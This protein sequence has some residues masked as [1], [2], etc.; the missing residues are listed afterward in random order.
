[1]G[2]VRLRFGAFVFYAD[3][4]TDSDDGTMA[5]Y[6]GS[7]RRPGCVLFMIY[8]NDSTAILQSL[9]YDL[10][11]ASNQPMPKNHG[12]RAML[13]AGLGFIRDQFPH[14]SRVSL[15]D[16]MT[17]QCEGKNVPT[18]NMSFVLHEKTWYERYYNAYPAN[19]MN[20]EELKRAYRLSKLHDTPFKRIYK[21]ILSSSGIRSSDAKTL[22]ETSTTWKE[23]YQAIYERY[24]CEPFSVI[25]VYK[26]FG[27]F[28][29]TLSTLVSQTW[30]I[31][32]DDERR[33]IPTIE[34]LTVDTFP[35]MDW[36]PL[37]PVKK[38]LFGGMLKTRR[39]QRMR[40]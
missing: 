4:Q 39:F 6:M 40:I 9:S 23:F 25:L 30:Y 24:Q 1:M 31:P 2:Y 33:T 37:E 26:P 17:F 8:P 16:E 21:E 22:Y 5:I 28:C 36:K 12:T 7:K 35:E 11:C 10:R 19:K 14:I 18:G 34:H 20:Y 15:S 38:R 13:N 29:D 27:M 32:M 3:V